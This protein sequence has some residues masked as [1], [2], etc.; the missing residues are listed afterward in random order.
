VPGSAKRT[1][2]CRLAP[3]PPGHAQVTARGRYGKTWTRQHG[4]GNRGLTVQIKQS[5][6]NPFTARWRLRVAFVMR[7]RF[8]RAINHTNRTLVMKTPH[9]PSLRP[10]RYPLLSLPLLAGLLTA[11]AQF[12]PPPVTVP[13]AE[14]P[15]GPWPRMVSAAN[16]D[17]NT[18]PGSVLGGAG[19]DNLRVQIPNSGPYAW[20]EARHNEGDIALLISP[21][22]PVASQPA[23][24]FVNNYI[25][26]T[27]PATHGWRV[28]KFLG[29]SL[30]SVRVNGRD[31]GDTAPGGGP[32]GTV[33]GVAYLNADFG[34]GWSYTMTTGTY[35]NGGDGAQDLQMGLLGMAN[36][37]GSSDGEGSFSCGVA[38]FPYSQG[39]IG[40]HVLGTAASIMWDGSASF[41]ANAYSPALHPSSV[42]WQQ[43]PNTF[44]FDRGHARIVLPMGDPSRGLLFGSSTEGDNQARIFAAYPNNGGWD[45]TLRDGQNLD[46]TGETLA[47]VE[48]IA[49]MFLYVPTNAMN[50]VGGHIAGATGARIV[51]GGD[52]TLTRTGAGNYE[53]TLPGKTGS[54]GV[55]L[56]TT[57]GA[58]T[59]SVTP[60]L[61]DRAV[62]SY[63]YSGGKFVIQ[64]R[65]VLAG[66]NPFGLAYNQRDTDFVFLWVDFKDPVAPRYP[67]GPTPTVPGSE[68]PPGAFPNQSASGANVDVN[69]VAGSVLGGAGQDNLWVQIPNSGPYA[70]TESRH[71]EGDIALLISPRDP[72][73]SQPADAFVNNYIATTGPATHG[74]RVN[75]F[76]GLSLASVRVNG[77]DNGDTAPGGGAVGT[78][79]GVA[80]LNADFG[81]GWSYTMTT[82]T[83]ANGGDGAQDLQMGLLGMANAPGSSDGEGSFSCGVAFFPY[84]QGWIGAHVLGT[85]ASVGFDGSATLDAAARSPLLYSNAV[86]WV[87]NPNT[88]GYDHGHA[89]VVMRAPDYK[90]ETA[91]LFGSSTEGDN[92]ARIFAAYPNNGGWDIT[93]RDGQNLDATGQTLANIDKMAFMFLAIPTNTPGLVG[94]HINGATGAKIISAG[95]YTLTRTAAGNYELTIPGKT[96]ADGMLL[97]TVAGAMAGSAIPNLG[98]RAVLSYEYTGGKFVIQAREVIAGGN[99]FGLAYNQRDTDFV[100]AWLDFR[101]PL[102][103]V[104]APGQSVAL[105]IERSGGNVMVSWPLTVFND[106]LESSPVLSPASWT[107]VTVTPATAA[108]RKSVSLPASGGSQ[109]F[110]LKRM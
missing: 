101:A 79:Y 97:L 76:L 14:Q 37:P 70:W 71:N 65:E 98:D 100:F 103:P 16:V 54:D 27:G 26:T 6:S 87:Q 84:A 81:Q 85:A 12:S 9:T 109:Y 58:Q 35:A 36:A 34:Q 72:V 102:H 99:A 25:A 104:G 51:S 89:R 40:A 67:S 52:Y 3:R 1:G 22:D 42:M 8:H 90:P 28:N 82:G 53:L 66:G 86:A 110:R 10:S 75:K 2:S 29:L 33:Y 45:I 46:A 56:L 15:P 108:D 47:N 30:T 23:D 20:T 13:A 44:G 24:A 4:S 21:R 92:Q 32:V 106:V 49:F 107:P 93:L 38:F 43:N 95:D 96:G 63:E 62:L 17:V 18:G 69:T 57:A 94:G 73:A 68:L 83:Y 61:G 50:F 19:Q 60:N 41:D 74:W 39:W 55:L 64:S 11:Q 48:K 7:G 59:G 77:R 5:I 88:F 78:V 105:T 80:Y 31:N 91:L